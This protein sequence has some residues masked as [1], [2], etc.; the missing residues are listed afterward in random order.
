MTAEEKKKKKHYYGGKEKKAGEISKA[1]PPPEPM[2]PYTLGDIQRD[3]DR[4][5][6]RFQRDFDDF[7]TAPPRHRHGHRGFGMMPFRQLASSVDL[8]DRGKDFRITAD[9]P[10]FVKDN[11]DIQVTDDAVTIQACKEESGE[12]KDKNYVRRERST[13]TF[14]RRIML[15][16]PV[17]SDDVQAMLDNGVLE[18]VL[19]KVK[20]KQSKKVKVS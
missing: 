17:Q 8:E 7:W 19:P 1:T 12:E 20:P 18:V 14:Y 5:M 13:Q 9:L 3:F 16:E 4:L 6:D 11:V 10:G 2:A 15:P